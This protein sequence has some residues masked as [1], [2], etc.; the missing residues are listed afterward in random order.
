MFIPLNSYCIC[1]FSGGI[2]VLD[3]LLTEPSLTKQKSAV[4]G[5][6]ELK[7]LLKYCEL[8]GITDKVRHRHGANYFG[9]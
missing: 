6:E 2:E 8:Y 1:V 4:E 9:K 3:A 5:L 7:L